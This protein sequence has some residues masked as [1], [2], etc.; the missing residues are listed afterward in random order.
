MKKILAILLIAIV[1]CETI[2]EIDL[3]SWW[4]DIRDKVE[5]AV[6]DAWDK[7]SDAVKKGIDY[8]KEKGIYDLLKDKV[9]QAGKA[10]AIAFCTP[11]LGPAICASAVEGVSKLIEN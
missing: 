4:T 9:I 7:L 10:A 6:K 1:A 3:E 2:Q 8:L 11:Y 5:D